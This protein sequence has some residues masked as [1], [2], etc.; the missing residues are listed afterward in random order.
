LTEQILV[1]P[2][3]QLTELIEE[4]PGL[5]DFEE[6][7]L[8]KIIQ[9]HGEFKP[10]DEMEH[11][12]EFKQIIP[13]M[14]MYNKDDEILTLIRTKSQ[15][16]KRLHNKVSLGIGGHI[17]IED[18]KDPLDAYKR[19]MEREINEEVDV[20]LLNK[21]QFLGVIYDGTTD[22][23]SVHLGMAFKVLINFRDINEKEKFEY[24]WKTSKELQEM[25]E[26][27]EGWSVH[28]LERL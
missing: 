26:S 23:G 17:N 2:A 20:D 6:E 5:H 9:I 14:A 1:V 27:M 11:N 25:T 19:G 7:R 28:I 8:E 16:E 22:V 12:P 4:N 15:S 21:P 24:S 18:S 13:Y 10:R 3:N